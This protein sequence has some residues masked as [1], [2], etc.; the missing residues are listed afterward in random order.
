MPKELQCHRKGMSGGHPRSET[1]KTVCRNDALNYYNRPRQ[2]EVAD[3][4][5]GP[6]WAA[7]SLVA[8]AS[9]L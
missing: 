1:I 2:P 3:V 8:K 7:C 5:E 9:D 6:G 4:I